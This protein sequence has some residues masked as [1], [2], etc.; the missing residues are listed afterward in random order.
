MDHATWTVVGTVIAS[1]LA[2]I[3]VITAAVV[4][5]AAGTREA[6][7][8]LVKSIA[9]LE[10][11][12]SVLEEKVAKL[13][14]NPVSEGACRDR[15]EKQMEAIGRVNEKQNEVIGQVQQG[16]AKLQA[17]AGLILVL[18]AVAIVLVIGV[19]S[20]VA[21]PIQ[22]E[23]VPVQPVV[24]LSLPGSALPGP[25]PGVTSGT[26]TGS[27]SPSLQED[28][29]AKEGDGDAL[30]DAPGTSPDAGAENAPDGGISGDVTETV[31]Q[32]RTLEKLVAEYEAREKARKEK[33]AA[34]KAAATGPDALDT[35]DWL[36]LAVL[37]SGLLKILVS[38]GQRL[39]LML[40]GQW[41][42]LAEHAQVIR[43]V[44]LGLGVLGGVLGHWGLGLSPARS[45]I[46]AIGSGPGA[47][48]L[49]ELAALADRGKWA[50]ATV[51]AKERAA[52]AR[53]RS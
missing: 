26:A 1:V 53:P 34:K 32:L 25:V 7:S 40:G 12:V 51:K 19:S 13:P 30:P 42:W 17:S 4:K 41:G 47:L 6:I 39:L 21:Q 23:A 28:P 22:P 31:A 38:R 52:A 49:H 20:A 16:I 3:G 9:V 29:G 35:I 43:L 2:A 45:L 27:G 14:A 5:T 18:T 11:R 37:V 44:L 10:G 36:G 50:A 48:L 8:V 15:H 46:L 24:D 33:A